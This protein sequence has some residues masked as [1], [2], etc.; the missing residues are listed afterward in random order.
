MII[1]EC[2]LNFNGDIELAKRMIC[3]AKEAGAD[4]VK[5]Q[6]FDSDKIPSIDW[7]RKCELSFDQAS[8]LFNIGQ[9]EGI[10]VFFSVFDV[11]RVRWC[12][13]IGVKRYKIANTL[14]SEEVIRAVGATGKPLIL[15][16][17]VGRGD[18]PFALAKSLCHPHIKVIYCRSSYPTGIE[19]LSF[20]LMERQFNGFSD[21]TIGLDASKIA[22]ARGAE[23]IEKHLTLDKNME[24]P[25]HQ[26]SMTPDE[27]RELK[28][29]EAVCQQV[30]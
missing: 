29:W 24:G 6:L 19:D 2:G 5:F 1:A 14:R 15:S 3:E 26:L 27:L 30:L 25:D 4:L 11:E 20:N 10:E 12:E 23:I 28:R 8:G 7:H 9:L 13:E 22:L 21:H 16:N 18:W 17:F